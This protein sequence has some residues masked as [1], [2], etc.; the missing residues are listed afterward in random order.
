MNKIYINEKPI[1]FLEKNTDIIPIP[2]HILLESLEKESLS[3]H[4]ADFEKDSQQLALYVVGK[5]TEK[6]FRKFSSQFITIEAG[7][8]LVMNTDGYYLFIFRRGKWDLPKG[9][10]EKGEPISDTALREVKEETGLE[11]IK[12][13]NSIGVTYHAFR[14]GDLFL[15]KKT[16]WFGMTYSGNKKPVPQKSEDITRIKWL[17]QE[18]IEKV[19]MKSTFASITN[20]LSDYFQKKY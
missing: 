12:V 20:L 1:I 2:G 15:L 19:V 18:E 4:I 14:E 5:D 11:N 13:N 6:T 3:I 9:K 7:G 16:Y 8:G 17:E 10:C